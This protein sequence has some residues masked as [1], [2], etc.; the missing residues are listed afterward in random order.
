MTITTKTIDQYNAAC[1]MEIIDRLQAELD[2]TNDTYS[3]LARVWIHLFD[4]KH[5][6][7]PDTKRYAID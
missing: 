2:T 3:W 6:Y 1:A 4:T 7:D 5:G